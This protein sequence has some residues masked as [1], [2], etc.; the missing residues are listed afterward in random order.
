MISCEQQDTE[1]NGG[2]GPTSP[3]ML[4][5]AEEPNEPSEPIIPKLKLW[6]L[7]SEAGGVQVRSSPSMPSMMI[8]RRVRKNQLTARAYVLCK[9]GEIPN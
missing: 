2:G 3:I 9:K 6:D 5:V 7:E 4:N 1:L 8:K